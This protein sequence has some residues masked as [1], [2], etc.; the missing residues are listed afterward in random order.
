MIYRYDKKKRHFCWDFK[1]K[2][3]IHTQTLNKYKNTTEKACK[4]KE[5][6]SEMEKAFI[7]SIPSFIMR[8]EKDT[9]NARDLINASE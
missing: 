8:Y 3:F 9:Q 6:F 7:T 2:S 4:E 1:M 5:I